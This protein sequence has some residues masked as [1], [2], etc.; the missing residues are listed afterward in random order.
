MRRVEA[1]DYAALMA[2]GLTAAIVL[3]SGPMVKALLMVVAGALLGA[4][5]T[6]PTGQ[7]R[8]TMGR[9][10]LLDGIG[11]MPIAIGLFALSEIIAMLTTPA[12]R[13]TTTE[14]GRWPLAATG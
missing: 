13:V 9:P 5:G 3:A 10:E 6:G 8:F 7:P 4:V 2:C 11:F 1:A 14:C 12:E